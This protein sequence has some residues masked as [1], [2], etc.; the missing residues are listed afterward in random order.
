MASI[1][2]SRDQGAQAFLP[3]KRVGISQRL[4]AVG[5]DIASEIFVYAARRAAEPSDDTIY[6]F[7]HIATLPELDYPVGE[8]D[9][10]GGIPWMRLATADLVHR[11][12]EE[13]EETWE[14]VQENVDSLV[15]AVNA[16]QINET[17]EIT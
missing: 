12:A 11:T 15:A 13:A 8:A 4:T 16:G 2:L 10:D 5:T 9:L 3:G 17:V 6:E 7:S 1:S 14:L